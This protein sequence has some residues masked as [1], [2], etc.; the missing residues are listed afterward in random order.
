MIVAGSATAGGP[1]SVALGSTTS[2]LLHSS[3]IPVAL[4]PRGFRA[5]PTRA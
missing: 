1:G 4:A 5:A 3:P 2:R